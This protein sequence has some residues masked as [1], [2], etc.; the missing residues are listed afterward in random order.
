MSNIASKEKIIEWEYKGLPIKALI[1]YWSKD[2][3]FEM[4]EP[5][6]VSFLG[7]H[8]MYIAPIKYLAEEL[9]QPNTINL[10]SKVKD[11]CESWLIKELKIENKTLVEGA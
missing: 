11:D 9:S 8:L 5:Y 2:Y 6:Q 3:N 7:G 1:H 4:V 10:V